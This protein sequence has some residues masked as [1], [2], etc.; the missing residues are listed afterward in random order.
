MTKLLNSCFAETKYLLFSFLIG[1]IIRL[2]PEILSFPYPIGFD[3]I[4]YASIMKNGNFLPNIISFFNTSWLLHAFTVPLY[5][6]T[7]IDI[8]SLLKI[9][10]PL[11]YGMNTAGIFWFSRRLL[12]WKVKTSLIAVGLFSIQLASLRISWDLLRNTLG[13][14]LLL[15]TLPLINQLESKKTMI[16]FV[17]FTFLTVIAHEFSAVTLMFIILGLLTWSSITADFQKNKIRL[18]VTSLPALTF[19]SI[20]ILLR[21]TTPWSAGSNIIHTAEFEN[22]RSMFFVNY[23]EANDSVFSISNY[24]DLLLS[25]A[26]LFFFLYIPLLVFIRKGFLK[27]KILN[28]WTGLLL[29]GTFG[30]LISP[31]FALD[32]WSRWM[33]MLS[34]PFTF[35]ATVG[36]CKLLKPS[37]QKFSW[38]HITTKKII[39]L[40]LIISI[41]LSS[42]YLVTPTLMNNNNLGIYSLPIISSHFSSA[43]TVPYADV[44]GTIQA[45]QWLDKQMDTNSCAIL[46][47]AFLS[48]GQLELN[49]SHIII[50]FWK[51]I[52]LATN[53]AVN[54]GFNKLFFVWWNNS[55]NWYQITV[56]NYFNETKVFDQISIYA[57]NIEINGNNLG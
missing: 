49:N 52:D 27:N 43:P 32:F 41:F 24:G 38:Y 3:T 9:I 40:M 42:I 19:A 56:P 25:V 33:F 8:F 15:F 34:Y 46:H 54:Q 39:Y 20:G 37:K 31:F 21:L 30:C 36:M 5:G 47:Q 10:G 45:M 14:S 13:M 55:N 44:N 53:I 16:L 57:Y 11:L 2:I 4:H 35:Y 22:G 48:W 29:I 17:I 6:F 26:L 50:Q 51:D 18:L 7:R 23:F 12:G 28:L 1:F